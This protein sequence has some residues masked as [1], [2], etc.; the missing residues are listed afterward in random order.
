MRLPETYLI[1]WSF[2]P[3]IDMSIIQEN[4]V[5]Y[6]VWGASFSLKAS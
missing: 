3:S 5:F 1:E 6:G 4:P 2:A